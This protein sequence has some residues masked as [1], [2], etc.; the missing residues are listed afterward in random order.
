M[1]IKAADQITMV[2]LTDACAV[3]LSMDSVSMS[4]TATNQLNASRTYEIVVNVIRGEEAIIPTGVTLGTLPAN[5]SAT[6]GTLGAN[7]TITVTFSA[8]LAADGSFEIE[9]TVGDLTYI[10][11]FS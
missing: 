2:D 4:A 11:R 6:V 1:A 8:D 9:V 7:T 3:Y 5:V 10:K